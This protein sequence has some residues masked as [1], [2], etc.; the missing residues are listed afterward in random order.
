[1]MTH[2]LGIIKWTPLI[3]PIKYA[4]VGQTK[5]H[6]M[7]QVSMG[8]INGVVDSDCTRHIPWH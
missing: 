7:I 3:I 6:P 5:C 4:I 2:L 8:L 1:M